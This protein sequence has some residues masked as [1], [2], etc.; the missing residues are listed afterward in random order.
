MVLDGAQALAAAQPS[1]PEPCAVEDYD[2]ARDRE[3]A[4]LLPAGHRGRPRSRLPLN[5]DPTINALVQLG[6]LRLNTKRSFLSLI[7]R[8]Y[9]Y[10]VSEM[11]QSHSI[12][13][14]RHAEGDAIWIGCCKLEACWG[15]CPTTMKAFLDETGEWAKT[16]PNIIA[17]RTRYIVNDFRTDPAY[18]TR[19]YVV[20]YPWFVS[21]IEVPLVS[22]LGYLLG[23]YC[24][25]DD[26]LHEF[27]NDET[28]DCLNEIAAAITA[29]LELIHRLRERAQ[30]GRLGALGTQ[31]NKRQHVG[32]R[33]G[34]LRAAPSSHLATLLVVLLDLGLAVFANRT[35]G[36]DARYLRAG[37]RRGQPLDQHE[38]LTETLA[39]PDEEAMSI[40]QGPGA[41]EPARA[42]T[43]RDS[44]SQPTQRRRTPDVNAEE[45]AAGPFCGVIVK[46]IAEQETPAGAAAAAAATPPIRV[47]EATLQRLIQKYER[48]HIFTADEFGPIDETYGAGKHF[49]GCSVPV[50]TDAALQSDVAAL[51]HAV[52]AAKYI[53]F[54]PLWHFQREC[55]YAA[56]LGWI[57][58]PIR[59]VELKDISLVSAFSNSVMAEVSRLE[60]LAANHAKSNF[61]SSISHELRTPLHGIMA[62]SELIRQ[63]LGALDPSLLPT[64][65]MLDSCSKTLLDTFNN[66][67]DYT[68]VL[69]GGKNSK[70]VVEAVNVSYLSENAF[71]TSMHRKPQQG[72]YST[73]V[74]DVGKDLAKH[75]VLVTLVVGKLPTV[76]LP[77][78]VG[79]WKRIVMNLFGNA[80]KYTD[81]GYIRTELTTLQRTERATG[82][83]RD[84]VSFTVEDTGCGMSTDYLK[85]QIFTPFSQED[86]HSPGTGLGLSIVQQLVTRLGGTVDVQSAVGRGEPD[87]DQLRGRTACLLSPALFVALGRTEPATEEMHARSLMLDETLRSIAGE[88]LGM[89]MLACGDTYPIPYADVYFIDA[90]FFGR[91]P[92]AFTHADI[93]KVWP[94]ILVS[95]GAGES[96]LLTPGSVEHYGICLRDPVAPRKLSA[97][98]LAAL[99]ASRPQLSLPE[100][101]PTPTQATIPGISIPPPPVRRPPPSR[102]PILGRNP[103]FPHAATPQTPTTS[104]VSAN[105]QAKSPGAHHVLLVDDNPINM[106]LL[107][108]IMS[109]LKH[110][111]STASNGQ[112][113][114]DLYAASLAQQ[115]DGGGGGGGPLFDTVFMD[116]TMPV[117]DGFE[118]TRE[119]RKL[120]AEAQIT[121]S[122][123]IAVTGLSSEL[124]RNN[125]MSSGCNLF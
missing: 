23:S 119:I 100:L 104:D 2:R 1:A 21:Y 95:S 52:P 94:L 48:G 50:G 108:N 96:S 86:Q 115:R 10:V 120:E 32:P 38:I 118:A 77:V 113:A 37:R 34:R 92:T 75:S 26:K 18:D 22:S 41:P 60:A 59:A 125:A 82:H 106:K 9:Q 67:L 102:Q 88:G 124:S 69:G 5:Q 90:G 98:L 31:H 56:A 6:A 15:V 68:V 71:L 7:D 72:I 61:V 58:D 39:D 25:V 116:L 11:T 66:L 91:D 30:D 20:D 28:V 110:T 105:T 83:V 64:L 33:H 85:Y 55:W 42:S 99:S 36:G 65:D 109:K 19:P 54:L 103:S 63:S 13:E 93:A 121:P 12:I 76:T 87:V 81:A 51:F 97:T 111:F 40:S 84:Y 57:A 24:V 53:V 35:A 4:A 79:A 8:N 73:R 78:D 27:D 112:E 101:C 14:K 70:D 74:L 62:S 89:Q 16:G 80:L 49:P 46:S 3:I 29:H 44:D 17:N 123:I 47:P 43:D 117:M 45:E 107:T 114:V 122:R